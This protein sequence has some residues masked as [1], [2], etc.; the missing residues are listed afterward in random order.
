MVLD[1][2]MDVRLCM[3]YINSVWQN[4][5]APGFAIDKTTGA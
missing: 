2:L 1:V 3:S 4:F 5:N